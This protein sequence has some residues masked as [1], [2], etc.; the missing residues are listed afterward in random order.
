MSLY[1]L[2]RAGDVESLLDYLGGAE[3]PVVRRRVALVLGDVGD[4][5]DPQTVDALIGCATDDEE[6]AVRAAAVDALDAL[7]PR[8]L[9]RFILERSG[10]VPED[11]AEWVRAKAFAATLSADGPE[12]RMAAAGAL[13][14]IDDPSTVEPLVG[15]LDDPEPGVRMR[16]ARALGTGGDD[17]AVPSLSAATGDDVTEVR[18]AAADALA[19]IGSP[20]ALSA[21]RSGLDDPDESVRHT[22]AV[23]L[24]G[25]GSLAPVDDLVDAL[26]DEA[27][28]VRRAA[29]FSLVDLLSGADGADGDAVRERIVGRLDAREDTTVIEPLVELLSEATEAPQRRNAAWL[30]GRIA[31]EAQE[32]AV[33]ALIDAL[34]DEDA[35]VG[36][37]AATSL[38]EVGGLSVESNLLEQLEDASPSVQAVVVYV[39]GRVGGDRSLERLEALVETTDHDL[40][41]RRAF[42]AVSRL[43][44]GR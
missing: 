29:A 17:R 33:A 1:E 2:E 11:A 13:G 5:E 8:P 31:T 28:F 40:V 43:G 32:T 14:R 35:L 20:A 42:A 4:P 27:S 7:G 9:E 23:A 15:A 22:A 19:A 34:D 30:L 44:G 21:L 10:Q 37:F 3:K 41:R 36:Q 24:G 18:R 25:V 12:M 26:D 38:V 16:V 39:L 6:P